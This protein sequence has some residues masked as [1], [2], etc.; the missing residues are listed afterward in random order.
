[1]PT[2]EKLKELIP[3][4]R[5]KVDE[6]AKKA[7]DPKNDLEVRS[8]KKKLKRLTRKAAKIVYMAKKKEEKKKKK[9]GGGDAA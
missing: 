2:L 3:T 7:S 8:K 6:A 9:K 5:K 1:M 4:A